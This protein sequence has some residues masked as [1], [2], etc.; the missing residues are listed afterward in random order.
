MLTVVAA[1]A[2]Q[3]KE[4]VHSILA[5][6]P[7]RMPLLPLKKHRLKDV[8]DPV[9]S[10]SSIHICPLPGA[11]EAHWIKHCI[12]QTIDAWLSEENPLKSSTKPLKISTTIPSKLCTHNSC[13]HIGEELRFNHDDNEKNQMGQEGHCS[14]QHQKNSTKRHHRKRFPIHHCGRF[15]LGQTHHMSLSHPSA[16]PSPPPAIHQ[17]N[18]VNEPS[19]CRPA[20]LEFPRFTVC[21]MCSSHPGCFQQDARS[22]EPRGE[23]FGTDAVSR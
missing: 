22:R 4:M 10:T 6:R 18:S 17:Q 19:T 20:V 8:S 1:P 12:L 9:Q 14:E 16:A 21:P 7:T 2:C 5:Q 13:I 15:P 11:W 3:S 23:S